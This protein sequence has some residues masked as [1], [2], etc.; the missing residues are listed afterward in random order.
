LSKA[1]T[2]D[3][4]R[5]ITLDKQAVSMNNDQMKNLAKHKNDAALHHCMRQKQ[6]KN[7]QITLVKDIRDGPC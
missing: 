5:K 3:F 4:C 6:P 1:Q 2:Y 7:S